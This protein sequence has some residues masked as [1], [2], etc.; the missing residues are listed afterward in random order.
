M[1]VFWSGVIS[2]DVDE[3][4]SWKKVMNFETENTNL[5]KIINI[6]TNT[7]FWHSPNIYIWK[8]IQNHIFNLL[9]QKLEVNKW[10]I[11]NFIRKN[12]RKQV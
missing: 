4:W 2:I 6:E 1:S 10:R 7:K 11:I 12:D 3:K 8:P 5:E 9:F